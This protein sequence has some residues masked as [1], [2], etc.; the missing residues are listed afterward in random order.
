MASHG[1]KMIATFKSSPTSDNQMLKTNGSN[2]DATRK[3]SFCSVQNQSSLNTEEL[4]K[5]LTEEE[6][7]ILAKVFQKE[8]EFQRETISR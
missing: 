6:K 2:L 8:E 7:Q 1:S 4:T 5:H 3:P